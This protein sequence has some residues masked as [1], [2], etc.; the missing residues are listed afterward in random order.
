MKIDHH[1]FSFSCCHSHPIIFSFRLLSYRQPPHPHPHPPLPSTGPRLSLEIARRFPQMLPPSPLTWYNQFV[2]FSITSGLSMVPISI[3]LVTIDSRWRG[4][5][6]NHWIKSVNLWLQVKSNINVRKEE[7]KKNAKLG[8]EQSSD[9]QWSLRFNMWLHRL[10]LNLQLP[11]FSNLSLTL[12]SNFSPSFSA[13][14][15]V[16]HSHWTES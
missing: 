14:S 8:W 16:V 15:P 7:R 6:H 11:V 9:E 10:P 13:S 1:T 2:S 4:I 3:P 12:S 5:I